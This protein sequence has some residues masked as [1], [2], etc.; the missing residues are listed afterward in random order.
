MT[1]LRVEFL[2]RKTFCGINLG[3]LEEAFNLDDLQVGPQVDYVPAD[4]ILGLFAFDILL[5]TQEI[6]HSMAILVVAILLGP[7]DDWVACIETEL[8][9][10]S[11]C[12]SG[13]SIWQL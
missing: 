10:Q 2:W 4:P 3:S 13:M 6:L 8:K 5:L 11:E 9:R 1:D 12:V 7:V